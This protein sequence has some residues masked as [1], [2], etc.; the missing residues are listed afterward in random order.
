MRTDA[1]AP[2]HVLGCSRAR[3]ASLA[4]GGVVLV[5][6]D[7]LAGDVV[8][9]LI[10]FSSPGDG[11]RDES[12]RQQGDGCDHCD[13]CTRTTAPSPHQVAP[14]VPGRTPATPREV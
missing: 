3:L 8:A 1:L 11:G 5:G 14:R 7:D 12:A 6:D 13:E 9:G 10:D 4:S 2:W